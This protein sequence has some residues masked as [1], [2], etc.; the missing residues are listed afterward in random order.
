MLLANLGRGIEMEV[1]FAFKIVGSEI[2]LAILTDIEKEIDTLVD[3]KSGHQTMLM[4]DVSTE[5]TN[6][7]RRKNVILIFHWE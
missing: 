6:A 3:G 7:I 5:G 2:D 4:V 1:H